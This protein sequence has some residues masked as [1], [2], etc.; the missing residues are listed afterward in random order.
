ME[1]KKLI[2]VGRDNAIHQEEL[3]RIMGISP[4]TTKIYIKQLRMQGEPI[5]SG[6]YGY[7]YAENDHEKQLFI[8]TMRK[9]AQSRLA[10]AEAIKIP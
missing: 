9:Q 2:P 8:N 6:V 10:S 3:S 4:R 5:L 7:W 1:I